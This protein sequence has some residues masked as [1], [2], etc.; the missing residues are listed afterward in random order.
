MNDVIESLTHD[1]MV[2]LLE[3]YAKNLVAL[4]GTWFQSVERDDGMDAAMH[5]DREAW[6][7]FSVSEARRIKGFLG[8]PEHPGREGL[9]QALPLRCQAAAIVDEIGRD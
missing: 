3:I 9:A 6:R 7:R 4:D 5:H 2:E 1:Q 8:L